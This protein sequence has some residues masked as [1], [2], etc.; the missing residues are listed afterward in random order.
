MKRQQGNTK[1]IDVTTERVLTS[2]AQMASALGRSRELFENGPREVP[3]CPAS[4]HEGPF[5]SANGSSAQEIKQAI[6]SLQENEER[7]RIAIEAG[8]M[9]AFEWD[10]ATDTVQRSEQSAQILGGASPRVG[11]TK[12]ELIHRMLPEDRQEYIAS[13]QSLTPDRREYKAIFRLPLDDGRMRWLKESGRAIF[14]ADGKLSKVIGITSDITEARESERALRDLSGRLISSQDEER[15]RIARELHDHIGQEIALLCMLAHRMDCEI[16]EVGHTTGSDVHELYRRMK[17][18]AA[19]VS[20]LSRRLYSSEL[21]Y[22]GLVVATERLCRDFEHQ[23]GVSV[24]CRAKSLPSNL[25][26]TRSLCIFR[27]LE[28][29][30]QNVMK[31]SHATHVVVTL[32]CVANEV[33]LT[34]EDNGNGFDV[35]KVSSGLGLLSMR[36]RV[37]FVGGRIA[38]NSTL[39][40]GTRVVACVSV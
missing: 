10:V 38:I 16:A 11:N 22:L 1:P 13:L 18:V 14:G 17:L 39:G 8:Q 31:H 37:H 6:Q 23:F 20:K 28:E 19:D 2:C 27:V 30:L 26:G 5:I 21:T 9:Y 12:Q 40:S 15:R 3:L 29:S 24:E 25:D 36:E 34:V 32:H 4:P 33:A 35:E 7:L